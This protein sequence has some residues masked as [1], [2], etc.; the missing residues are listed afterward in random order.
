M[1]S[2]RKIPYYELDRQ[3]DIDYLTS[4]YIPKDLEIQRILMIY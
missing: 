2:I 4:L 3:E 1:E